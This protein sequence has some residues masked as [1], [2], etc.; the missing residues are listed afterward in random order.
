LPGTWRIVYFYQ[1]LRRGG[2]MLNKMVIL[3]CLA[4]VLLL[5]A[6]LIAQYE[7]PDTNLFKGVEDEEVAIA[8][9]LRP[10]CSTNRL[11]ALGD[12]DLLVDD[13]LNGFHFGKNIG[14]M[15][16]NMRGKMIIKGIYFTDAFHPA[17]A[18]SPAS[19]DLQ[20]RKSTGAQAR[21]NP[22]VRN[23]EGLIVNLDARLAMSGIEQAY[24]N[25]DS[26]SL[27]KTSSL[28]CFSN[29]A[30]IDPVRLYSLAHSLNASYFFKS[31]INEMRD[32]ALGGSFSKQV[33][34]KVGF[35]FKL[36]ISY[37]TRGGNSDRDVDTSGIPISPVKRTSKVIDN[38]FIVITPQA[39]VS[40][41]PTDKIK[42]GFFARYTHSRMQHDSTSLTPAVDTISKSNVSISHSY[43]PN[44]ISGGGHFI[45]L[46]NNMIKLGFR[47]EHVDMAIDN[48]YAHMVQA[49][50][51][52]PKSHAN[53]SGTQT[54][55][56]ASY[57]N[58]GFEFRFSGKEKKVPLVF[59]FAYDLDRHAIKDMDTSFFNYLGSD[60]M[61]FNG[62]GLLTDP[63]P[64][65][66]NVTNTNFMGQAYSKGSMFSTKVNLGNKIKFGAA[67]A[68]FKSI[69][70]GLQYER[71]FIKNDYTYYHTLSDFSVKGYDQ[72]VK[73]GGEYLID[74]TFSVRLGLTHRSCD[75][76]KIDPE[77]FLVQ[78]PTEILGRD[79]MYLD[80]FK[81]IKISGGLGILW[82]LL[83]IDL[84]LGYEMIKAGED[85]RLFSYDQTPPWRTS[86][87]PGKLDLNRLYL[88][89]LAS[90][91]F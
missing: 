19:K 47:G 57:S 48:E 58:F 90:K 86:M 74:S 73:V 56:L 61:D 3:R 49:W 32:P 62:S 85:F 2:K 64:F 25:Y 33:N 54:L 42:S 72:K 80:G 65:F 43:S 41:T 60:F 20:N 68:D 26:S 63:Y 11:L 9:Q 40:I 88:E 34:E 75:P 12:M 1:K 6:A 44:G 46:P 36:G 5:S 79:L 81:S 83:E 82:D 89:I 13:Y 28:A 77:T 10:F 70:A 78:D 27:K 66:D 31:V 67:Y 24:G 69:T 29:P 84:A 55:C 35:G 7:H 52:T 4:W 22:V 14:A 38:N 21:L 37:M 18:D 8:R 23:R 76:N 50:T 71:T 91:H 45:V 16:N 15:Y 87:V 51:Q 59:G 53:I 30:H 39:G 17:P